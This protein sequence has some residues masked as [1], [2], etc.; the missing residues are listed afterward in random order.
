MVSVVDRQP[1]VTA[2]VG[3]Y[4]VV[5]TDFSCKRRRA[6]TIFAHTVKIKV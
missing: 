5:L 4:N 3:A 2:V 1:D 6:F